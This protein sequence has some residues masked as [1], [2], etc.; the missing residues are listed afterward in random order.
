[1]AFSWTNEIAMKKR[2]TAMLRIKYGTYF[3]I[4]RAET[5]S[6]SRFSKEG[7]LTG[8]VP[9][10]PAPEPFFVLSQIKGFLNWRTQGDE[11]RTACLLL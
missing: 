11:F 1:M 4:W 10:H 8:T 9:P 3:Q 2:L 5:F 7:I 6:E